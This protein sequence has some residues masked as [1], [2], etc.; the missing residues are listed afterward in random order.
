MTLIALIAIL[1]L[2]WTIFV[3]LAFFAYGLHQGHLEEKRWNEWL[4]RREENEKPPARDPADW[5]KVK[6]GG[7]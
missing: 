4:D 5:W 3:A 7:Y 6:G 1:L 2:F